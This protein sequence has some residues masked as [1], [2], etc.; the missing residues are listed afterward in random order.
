M[1][2]SE[3]GF[4]SGCGDSPRMI[5]II[6]A[7]SIKTVRDHVSEQQVTHGSIYKESLSQVFAPQ[8]HLVL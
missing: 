8:Y 6:S 1:V 3:Y 5:G 4:A 7:L 2:V